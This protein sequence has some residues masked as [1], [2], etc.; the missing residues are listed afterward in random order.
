MT[1][2]AVVAGHLCL[3]IFPDFT[4]SPKATLATVLSPGCLTEV[5][6]ATLSTGGA[7]SNTGLALNKLGLATHLIGK[8]GDDFFGQAVQNIIASHG[9]H[10]A[11]GIVVDKSA[12]TSYTIII[13]LPAVDR[14]FLHCPGVNDTF[15]A[16]DIRDER[17]SQARLFHFGYPTVIKSMYEPNGAQ[18]TAMFK[19]AKES[20]VTTSLD[21]ALP[22]PASASG[23]ADWATILQSTLPW[24]DIFLPS[25]E[26]I[27]YMLRRETFEQMRRAGSGA[28]FLSQ[29]TPELLSDLSRQLEAMG[30]KIVVLKL[31][32][33][34]LYMRT[35]SRSAIENLGR[36]KPPATGAWADR[37]MWAPCFQVQVAGT[38]GCGDSTIAG[39]LGGLLRGL[40][41]EMT[42]TVAVAVGACNVEAP[43]ALSGIRPWRETLDRITSGWTRRDLQLTSPG[44]HWEQEPGLWV[45]PC[46]RLRSFISAAP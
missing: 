19:R 25:I 41:P 43:D 20:G 11:D 5:G 30:V 23:R 29:A 36:A 26:E 14:I 12:S 15:R 40:S 35:A 28:G 16:S 38:T 10:L 4:V 18:L 3:D 31:G 6:T 27:L 24:V 34:G 45:G 7:V 8:V 39:F 22:D 33:R 9:Q 21:M 42:L 1:I 2:D 44:W 32:E 46:F 17:L 13:N 37:E